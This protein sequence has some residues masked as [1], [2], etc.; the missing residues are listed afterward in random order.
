MEA[1]LG[2]LPSHCLS[3]QAVLPCIMDTASPH[4]HR[5][6]LLTLHLKP[7]ARLPRSASP[8]PLGP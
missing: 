2:A 7:E 5:S 6:L 1:E 4:G 8:V 3:P